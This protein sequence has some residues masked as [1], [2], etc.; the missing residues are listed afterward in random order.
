MADSARHFHACDLKYR[1]GI[2]LLP[3]ERKRLRNGAQLRATSASYG[4]NDFL[5]LL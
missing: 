1:F 5:H 2:Q 4:Y 3:K